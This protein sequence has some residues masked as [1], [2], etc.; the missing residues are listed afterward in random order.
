MGELGNFAKKYTEDQR[1]FECQ[2]EAREN[3]IKELSRSRAEEFVGLMRKHRVPQIP[4]CQVG[5][6]P[7]FRSMLAPFLP[8]PY[9]SELE[10]PKRKLS[11][12][13]LGWVAIKEIY[14]ETGS[15]PTGIFIS[16]DMNAYECGMVRTSGKTEYVAPR[17]GSGL[18][19]P[20]ETALA[21]YGALDGLSK[22]IME[23]GIKP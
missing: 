19:I 6:E 22:T 10:K 12:I 3:A 23:L 17:F 7:L 8:N 11:V 15:V 21:E 1:A 18:V 5:N 2:R 4:L 9:R 14:A 20:N 16:S 13:H